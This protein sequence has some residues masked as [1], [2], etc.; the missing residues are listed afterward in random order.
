MPNINLVTDAGTQSDEAEIENASQDDLDYPG[1][2]PKDFEQGP[3]LNPSN[4]TYGHGKHLQ[5]L[6]AKLATMAFGLADIEVTES[7]FVTLADD[8]PSRYKEAMSSINAEYWKPSCHVKYD[9][10]IGYHT[11]TLVERPPNTN[12]VGN[13]W[14]FRIKRDNL[15][16]VNKFKSC[17]VA[18][19]FS[20]IE[21]LNYNETYSPTIRFTTIC[22]ILALACKY[23]LELCHIDIKGAYLNGKLEDVVYM[24][25]PEGFVVEGKEHMVCKLNKGVY[26]LKQSGRVWH[27]TLKK[28]LKSLSVDAQTHIIQC[29]L[30]SHYS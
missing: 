5:A 26:G 11:W 3:W 12:I 18:Q 17:L 14:I 20:Q 28:G 4:F 6:R 22:L 29:C 1:H 8:E 19:G 25:Q 10:L 9:T 13:R 16:L 27:Q 23:D 2:A 7:A 15:G 24:C 21:G 30:R